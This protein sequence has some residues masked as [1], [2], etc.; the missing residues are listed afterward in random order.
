MDTASA[1]LAH[2]GWRSTGGPETEAKECPINTVTEG[3]G[4]NEPG[5]S[6]T[7]G[8]NPTIVAKALD[9]G[10]HAGMLRRSVVSNFL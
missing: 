10:Q 9:L 5:A 3:H 8:W 6:C 4:F 2:T 7:P 1:P